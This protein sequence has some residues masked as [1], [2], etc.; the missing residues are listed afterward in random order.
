MK[1]YFVTQIKLLI[2]SDY[3]ANRNDIEHKKCIKNLQCKHS[4][5][6]FEKS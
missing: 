4:H 5:S 2:P 1:K 3:S 6:V